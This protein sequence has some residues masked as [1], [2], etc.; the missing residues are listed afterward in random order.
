MKIFN[1]LDICTSS[2]TDRPLSLFFENIYSRLLDNYRNEYVYKNAIASKIVRGRHRL[3]NT[4]FTTEFKV[5]Q[6]I[7]DVAVFNGTSTAY[8]IKTEFD[9]FERLDSQLKAYGKVFDKTYVVVPESKVQKT[10]D[11][12]PD[13]V[14]VYALTRNYSLI[15]EKEA[16]SNIHLLCSEQMINCL[17]KSEYLKVVQDNFDY[18]PAISPS[19]LKRDC[20]N[21]FSDL[22]TVDAHNE[23][24][25]I[26]KQRQ[27]DKYEKDVIKLLPESL[28]SLA[29]SARLNKKLLI[30]FYSCIMNSR[31]IQTC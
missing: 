17:R 26:L 15:I 21:L 22:S 31:G 30:K 19:Q 10:V 18:V 27:L 3:S 11:I 29:L 7:A 5:G 14:G 1:E 4:S 20:I 6:S 16:L 25:R 23:F 13:H 28:T 8:E 12:V 9:T 2:I 24:V